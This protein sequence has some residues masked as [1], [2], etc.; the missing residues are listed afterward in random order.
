MCFK[1]GPSHRA[2][3]VLFVVEATL[4]LLNDRCHY[5]SRR[6]KVPKLAFQAVLVILSHDPFDPR[7]L[8]QWRLHKNSNFGTTTRYHGL[9]VV[10]RIDCAENKSEA[11]KV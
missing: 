6:S 2:V 4:V 9:K 1:F 3:M 7:C 10:P 8:R 5:C 11:V